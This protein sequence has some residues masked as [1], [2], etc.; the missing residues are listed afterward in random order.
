ML[1]QS[2]PRIRIPLFA[3]L[4]SPLAWQLGRPNLF[5]SYS[6]GVIMLQMAGEWHVTTGSLLHSALGC[7]AG[8]CADFDHID[9]DVLATQK[10][11]MMPAEA[12]A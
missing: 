3:A 1:P 8:N 11:Q 4:L 2:W 6:A 9:C 7:A 12:M 10:P 5:D